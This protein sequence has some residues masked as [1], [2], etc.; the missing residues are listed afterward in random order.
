MYESNYGNE[1]GVLFYLFFIAVY[2]Y[3]TFA[4]Y[5]IAQK[6]GHHSSWWA[7][8]PIL[9]AFQLVQLAGKEW[10]WFLLLFV[11]VLNIV[12]YAWCW[13]DT[14]KRCGHP[15]IWGF[16]TIIPFLNFISIGIMGFTNG[17]YHKSSPKPYHDQTAP[18]EHEKVS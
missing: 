3:F 9:N 17:N 14:A 4:Q 11:P 1:F 16:L 2:F 7:F 13:I 18:R 12:F 8:V 5:K 15:P 6:I 10:W